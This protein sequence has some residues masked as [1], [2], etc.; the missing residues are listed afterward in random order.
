MVEFKDV[1][2]SPKKAAVRSAVLNK[3]P[4]FI[5]GI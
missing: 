4:F 2:Q 3:A 1:M 5:G